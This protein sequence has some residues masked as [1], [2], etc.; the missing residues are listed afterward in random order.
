MSPIHHS[1]L[2]ETVSFG[3]FIT[4][5]ILTHP[6][7]PA[8]VW[9]S[10]HHRKGL[11]NPE[12][13]KAEATLKLLLRCLW[14]PAHLNWWIGVIFA[15]GASCFGMAS[16]LILFPSLTAEVAISETDINRIFFAGSIPFSIAAWLQLYQA[17]NAAPLPASQDPEVRER[18]SR[19]IGWRPH[20]IGWVSCALQFIGTLLFNMNTFNAMSSNLTWVQIDLWVWTPNVIG[21][22]LFLAS[23]YLAFIEAGHSLWSW[24][25]ASLS[26]WI[27]FINLLGCIGFMTSAL[28]APLFS[29]TPN[30]LATTISVF[31]TLLGAIC[32][33]VGS[34]LMLP[35]TAVQEVT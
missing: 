35:E 8:R 3:P 6:D 14:L 26:W 22:I 16:T 18:R 20:E 29:E 24:P 5:G 10:R 19:L 15:V 7:K 21:S 4:R 2:V 1:R 30:P 23:G 25:H 34:L 33:F 27:V 12:R 13:F 28:F 9:L 17:A 31:C 11:A 32:F